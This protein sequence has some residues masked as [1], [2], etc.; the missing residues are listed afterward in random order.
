MQSGC[1]DTRLAISTAEA[2]DETRASLLLPNA[3]EEMEEVEGEKV[4]SDEFPFSIEITTS[5]T[6]LQ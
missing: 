1:P 2:L 6:P 3:S 4:I 5:R